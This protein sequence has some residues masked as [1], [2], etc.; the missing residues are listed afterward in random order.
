MNAFGLGSRRNVEE[1]VVGRT[2]GEL[3]DT[4]PPVSDRLVC[5]V[6]RDAG[7]L[8]QR[9]RL[10]AVLL[11]D[12]SQLAEVDLSATF[13]GA[14]YATACQ[15]RLDGFGRPDQWAS[16]GVAEEGDELLPSAEQPVR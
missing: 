12:L 3:I 6:E 1:G 11:V 16:F 7:G 15:Q 8:E 5:P 13:K 2:S 14:L 10:T 9:A 4:P